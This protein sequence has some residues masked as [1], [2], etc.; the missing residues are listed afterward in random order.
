MK[1][2]R[3]VNTGMLIVCSAAAAFAFCVYAPYNIYFPNAEE[4]TFTFYD[5]WWM[6]LL[7]FAAVAAALIGIGF[8]FPKFR[9]GW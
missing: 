8:V 4:F 6:P 2:Y 7:C 3:K 5:F 1:D 9:G